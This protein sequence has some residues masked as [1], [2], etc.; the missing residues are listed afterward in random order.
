MSFLKGGFRGAVFGA[1]IL[2][3]IAAIASLW[4]GPGALAMGLFG[5]GV[6]GIG[7]GFIGGALGMGDK[8]RDDDSRDPDVEKR[9][10]D[11]ER[12]RERDCERDRGR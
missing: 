7:G 11:L 5:A 10:D 9:L 12:D 3:T 6:G 8:D 1:G 4:M 2:G